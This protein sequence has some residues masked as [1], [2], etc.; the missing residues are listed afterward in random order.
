MSHNILVIG[1]GELGTEVLHALVEHPQDTTVAVLLRSN[2]IA[3]TDPAKQ[4]Q[5]QALQT[6]GVRL[7]PGDIVED[8]EQKLA[9]IFAGYDTIIGCTGFVSGKGTQMKSTRAVLAAKTARYIPWQFGVDYDAI[10]RGS[11]QDVFDEQLDVRDLLR[12]QQTTRWAI[13]STGM[14]TSF[15]FAP[16]FGVVD[17]DHATVCALGSWENRVTVTTPK[18]IGRLTAE[19][20]LGSESDELFSNK[21]IFVGGDTISYGQ[22]AQ[23]VEHVAQKPIT[24]R[25]LSV[26]DM[27][28][29]LEN[30]PT[31][32]MLKYQ[33]V[34]GQGRGVAWDLSETWNHRGIRAK[35]AEE[36]AKENLV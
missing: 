20:V 25:V 17:L 34:F 10:G 31:N 33:I 30:D 14:F 6:L 29:A 8:S 27:Q 24:R 7:V 19:I 28:V 4:T 13:V 9:S 32:A 3:S 18:D 22:L 26:A 36:W 11:A 12:S 5:I 1:A 16:F 15:L 2:S 23:L 35:T 21:A